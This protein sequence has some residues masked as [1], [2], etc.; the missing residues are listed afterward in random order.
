L[1]L[2]HIAD[3]SRWTLRRGNGG[4]SRLHWWRQEAL[5]DHHRCDGEIVP[6]L[7]A[8]MPQH[9]DQHDQETDAGDVQRPKHQ[10]PDKGPTRAD[11]PAVEEADQLQLHHPETRARRP[12]T[13]GVPDQNEPADRDDCTDHSECQAE[14]TRCGRKQ[15]DQRNADD[16]RDRHVD[17]IRHETLA[18]RTDLHSGR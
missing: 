1:L 17:E 4:P 15:E 5:L 13:E 11:R 18:E 8:W 7:L 16:D 6:A 12:N 9:H 2:R 10:C 14:R 3:L